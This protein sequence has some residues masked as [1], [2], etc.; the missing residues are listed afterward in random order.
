MRFL[1][2]LGRSF[3]NFRGSLDLVQGSFLV[4]S[5][6]E[7]NRV[8]ALSTNNTHP[9]PRK[10]RGLTNSHSRGEAIISMKVGILHL[11]SFKMV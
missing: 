3:K 5:G 10:I 1:K 9:P 2:R 11:T 6:W 7:A 8:L 4:F